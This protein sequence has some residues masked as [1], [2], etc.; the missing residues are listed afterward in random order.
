MDHLGL[1]GA[2]FGLIKLASMLNKTSDKELPIAYSKITRVE[3]EFHHKHSNIT[4]L[5]R[6][7][8]SN[9]V[10]IQNS[11]LNYYKELLNLNEVPRIDLDVISDH[12]QNK[13]EGIDKAENLGLSI[14]HNI[15]DLIAA[16]EYMYDLCSYFGNRN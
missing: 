5:P 11:L 8:Y 3:D 9:G 1:I 2:I 4:I 10:Y 7:N 12:F 13:I 15:N 16:R 6:Y 14:N